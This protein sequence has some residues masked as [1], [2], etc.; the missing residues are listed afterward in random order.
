MVRPTRFDVRRISF[1]A[2]APG[3]SGFHGLAFLRGDDRRRTAGGDGVM[4]LAGGEGAIGGDWGDLL[5]GR[6]SAGIGG[7]RV[8][9]FG[10]HHASPHRGW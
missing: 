3:L 6:G 1:R 2:T 4:A 8:E 9:Q 5:A 10:Q 7:D